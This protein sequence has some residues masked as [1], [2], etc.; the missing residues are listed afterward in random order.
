MRIPVGLLIAAALVGFAVTVILRIYIP[1]IPLPY[2]AEG[3]ITVVNQGYT[4]DS[5][6]GTHQITANVTIQ[7]AVYKWAPVLVVP[8]AV[9]NPSKD[10]YAVFGDGTFMWSGLNGAGTVVTVLKRSDGTQYL[11]GF[12]LAVARA[13]E[14][15]VLY[16]QLF[17]VGDTI[18]C[19]LPPGYPSPNFHPVIT[20][21]VRNG[22]RYPTVDV[23][24]AYSAYCGWTV[25]NYGFTITLMAEQYGTVSPTAP[26]T[27]GGASVQ[28]ATLM[29]VNATAYLERGWLIAAQATQPAAVTIYLR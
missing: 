19:Y 16:P 26:A 9:W 18:Q 14:Y 28:S 12:K 13:G 17:T 3:N 20:V 29:P 24:F 2:Y 8:A 23:D 10:L 4:L 6:Y 1:S 21:T 22:T 7:Y 27:F 11:A 5:Y 15:Y 25:P